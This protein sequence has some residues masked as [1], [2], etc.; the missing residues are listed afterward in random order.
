M[1]NKTVKVVICVLLA[2]ILLA[3]AVLPLLLFALG[4]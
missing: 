4:M 2:V 1:N 3:S